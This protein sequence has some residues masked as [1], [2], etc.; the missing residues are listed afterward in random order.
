ML[1]L[2]LLLGCP[3][4]D[5]CRVSDTPTAELGHGENG[6]ESIPD[7]GEVAFVFGSQG[8][9]HLPLAVDAT[10]LSSDELV[11]GEFVGTVDGTEVARSQPWLNFRCN[12]ETGTQQAWNILL[13]FDFEVDPT[14]LV[15]QTMV[16]DGSLRDERQ[17]EVPVDAEVVIADVETP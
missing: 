10:G 3:T 5:G 1:F 2:A 15:G 14:T 8:G 12:P 4:P 16:I 17:I 6:F 11:V 9:Y 13:L 7:D